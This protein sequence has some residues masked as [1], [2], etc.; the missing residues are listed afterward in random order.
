MTILKEQAARWRHVFKLDPNRTISDLA[1]KLV[2]NAGTD[3]II[4]GGTDGITFKNTRDLLHRVREYGVLCVQEVSEINAVVPGFDGYLIPTVINTKEARWIHGAHVDALRKY[5]DL[6][7]WDKV[8]LLGYTVLNPEAKVARLT[9]AETACTEEQ[10][11]AYA[12]LVEHLFCWP[13]LYIE[14]SGRFGDM[15]L[16]DAAQRVCRKSRIFYGGGITTKEQTV[17]AAELADTVVVGN[18]IYTHA[19]RAAKTVKWVK[20]TDR[21]GDQRVK[22]R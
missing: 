2:C 8:L 7:P 14:Y 22:N 21:K 5:G 10:M 3:A 11:V 12:R 20:E 9:Q 17:A 15:A 19:E 13:V 1:L 4:V 18:L 6:I 16:V